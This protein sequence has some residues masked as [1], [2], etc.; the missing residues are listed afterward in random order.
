MAV[1][2]YYASRPLAGMN[3]CTKM[4]DQWALIWP[5]ATMTTHRHLAMR[6]HDPNGGDRSSV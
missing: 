6:L 1:S 2:V 4:E 5:L 3:K